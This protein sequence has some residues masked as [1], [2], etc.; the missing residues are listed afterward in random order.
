MQYA[1]SHRLIVDRVARINLRSGNLRFHPLQLVVAHALLD[2]H[3][4]LLAQRRFDV[5]HRLAL[6]RHRVE[7]EQR[8][9]AINEVVTG[10]GRICNARVLDQFAIES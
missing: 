8:R 4:D 5:G 6:R 9:A 3:A 1:N 7:H 2:Q 10:A